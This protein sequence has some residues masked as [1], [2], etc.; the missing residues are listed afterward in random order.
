[1]LPIVLIALEA[2]FF[3]FLLVEECPLLWLSIYAAVP[4]AIAT[5]IPVT[6]VPVALFM[7][8]ASVFI[9]LSEFLS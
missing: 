1:M 2:F 3:N 8:V 7:C 9:N 6:A 4:A 5:A